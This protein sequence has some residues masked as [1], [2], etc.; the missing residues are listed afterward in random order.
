[1]TVRGEP[2]RYDARAGTLTALGRTAPL[3]PE[4]GRVKLR[5]LVDRTSVE[6]FAA[7][8]R[9]VMCSCF[10]PDPSDL[11][12]ALTAEGGPARIPSL[13]VHALKSAWE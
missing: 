4:N 5:V 10:V 7:D 1:L 6:V 3:K 11:T 12:L 2:I 8:G 13:K 9:L